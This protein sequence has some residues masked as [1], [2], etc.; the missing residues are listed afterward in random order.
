MLNSHV[1]DLQ[2][3]IPYHTMSAPER[4]RYWDDDRVHLRPEGYDLMGE[5]IG[6]ALV[7]LIMPPGRLQPAAGARPAKKRRMN[8]RD[9]NKKFE[10]EDGDE[11]SLDQGWI[12]V[13]RKDL[14]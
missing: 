8:F 12:I 14:E 9:D 6:A 7:A 2:A 10:E 3:A 4:A 13:R 5:K 11:K 1:F